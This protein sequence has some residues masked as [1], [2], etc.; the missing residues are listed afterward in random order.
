MNRYLLKN[1]DLFS[2][3]KDEKNKKGICIEIENGIIKEIYN[4]IPVNFSGEIIDLSGKFAIPG[5]I[6]SHCHLMLNGSSNMTIES[7]SIYELVKYLDNPIV[8]KIFLR[9]MKKNLINAINTG[10]TTLVS[11]GDKGNLDKEL[12][13]EVSNNKEAFPDIISSGNALLPTSGHGSILGEMC[14]GSLEFIKGIR[15]NISNGAGIIKIMGTGGVMDSKRIGEAGKRKMNSTEIFAA[16]E[17]AH[18]QGLLLCSHV[19]SKEGIYDALKNGVDIIE[20]GAEITD[21]M[22]PLFKNNNKTLNG[23]SVVDPTISASVEIIENFHKRESSITEIQYKNTIIVFQRIKNGFQ[24]ALKNEIKTSIGNDAGVPFT[25]HNCFWKE[26]KYRVDFS[27]GLLNNK[28]VIHLATLNNAKIL[29][30]DDEVGSIEVGKKADILV[31]NNNPLIKLETLKNPF[32]VIK[33]G[34]IIKPN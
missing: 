34:N 21:E 3:V 18:N 6:N 25:Y 26:L 13:N 33:N 15:K 2:G 4:K 30:V 22:V 29:A 27:E 8:R 1:L 20:H 9:E 32:M 12:K 19:Q 16:S 23:Y 7:F 14:D 17:E 28:E 31:L 24:K 10:V 11:L 5:L